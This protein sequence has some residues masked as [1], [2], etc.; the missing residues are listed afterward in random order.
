RPF[1]LSGSSSPPPLGSG[2]QSEV[3]SSTTYV[4]PGAHEKRC[5]GLLLNGNRSLHSS[6]GMNLPVPGGRRRP[7]AVCCCW[8]VWSRVCSCFSQRILP[9][10]NVESSSIICATHCCLGESEGDPTFCLATHPPVTTSLSPS[11]ASAGPPVTTSLSPSKASAGP[12]VTTSLSP[13]KASAGPP[14]TTS[15]SPSKASAALHLPPP[16]LARAPLPLAPSKS[17]RGPPI[18]P[19]K[20]NVGPAFTPS[21]LPPQTLYGSSSY[22]QSPRSKPSVDPAVTPSLMCVNAA[23]VTAASP[24]RSSSCGLSARGSPRPSCCSAAS[25]PAEYPSVYLCAP[26]GPGRRHLSHFRRLLPLPPCPRRPGPPPATTPSRS[27]PAC[28]HPPAKGS[29]ASLSPPSG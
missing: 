17:S 13:S 24:S 15:L 7:R 8:R 21:I 29:G 12:P 3:T 18:T 9:L 27:A 20:S 2:S 5:A 25:P 14:V 28:P 26:S 19:S 4:V 10:R 22:P 1:L 16:N 6:G 11:K 23:P